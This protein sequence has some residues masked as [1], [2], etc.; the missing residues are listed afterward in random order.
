MIPF[1][2]V[3]YSSIANRF[4]IA[5][6]MNIQDIDVA[7]LVAWVRGYYRAHGAIDFIILLQ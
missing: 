7:R 5:R 1:E 4:Y 2:A 6:E 3:I